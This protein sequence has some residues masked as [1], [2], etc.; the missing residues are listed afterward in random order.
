[1]KKKL[2]SFTLLS[3]TLLSLSAC[4]LSNATSQSG[5]EVTETGEATNSQTTAASSEATTPNLDLDTSNLKLVRNSQEENYTIVDNIEDYVGTYK[6][7]V[8]TTDGISEVQTAV[9]EDGTFQSII[10]P[11]QTWGSE[12]YYLDGSGVVKEFKG[13]TVDGATYD[14]V[15]DIKYDR[16]VLVEQFGNVYLVPTISS[17]RLNVVVDETGQINYTDSLLSTALLSY[18]KPISTDEEWSDFYQNLKNDFEDDSTLYLDNLDLK[19]YFADGEYYL[20]FNHNN[21]HLQVKDLEGEVSDI[22]KNSLTESLNKTD[23]SEYVSSPN[24]LLNLT[25]FTRNIRIASLENGKSQFEIIPPGTAV[26]DKSTGE[27][28]EVIYGF[29]YQDEFETSGSKTFYAYVGDVFRIIDGTEEN[30]KYIGN[31]NALLNNF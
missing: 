28:Y 13:T 4:G 15:M 7:Y 18:N 29:V 6:G 21:K 10:T 23:V 30:G 8:T 5:S 17:K 2:F 11:L 24:A 20:S 9:F 14:Y 27:Q 1:M 12:R 31:P 16:G 19:S 3:A 26:Y 25:H 22:V